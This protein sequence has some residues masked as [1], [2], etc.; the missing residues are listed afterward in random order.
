ML[1]HWTLL[2]SNQS[3]TTASRGRSY[4]KQ[5]A[6]RSPRPTGARYLDSSS[7]PAHRHAGGLWDPWTTVRHPASQEDI[8]S[9]PVWQ[10]AGAAGVGEGTGAG[11]GVGVGA[12]G[13]AGASRSRDRSRRRSRSN[14]SR[15]SSRSSRS[16]SRSSRSRSGSSRSSRSSR[17]RYLDSSSLSVVHLRGDQGDDR[18]GRLGGGRQETGVPRVKQELYTSMAL[19][20]IAPS[21]GLN[22]WRNGQQC[23][24]KESRC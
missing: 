14:R 5:N 15:R 12:V 21:H 18:G 6:E 22:T 16:R 19:A 2:E 8:P 3:E 4:C 10:A 13:A 24:E 9:S 11:A 7:P 17:A 23:P 1:S 20:P